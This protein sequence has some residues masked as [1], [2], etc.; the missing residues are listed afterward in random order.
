MNMQ[1]R[2]SARLLASAAALLLA[3]TLTSCGFDYATDRVYTPGAGTNERDALVDVLNAVIVSGQDGSGTFV[4]SF[5]NN[6]RREEASVESLEGSGEFSSLEVEDFEPVDL[7]PGQLVNLAT[8]GGIVVR[9]EFSPGDFVTVDISFGDGDSVEM[10]VPTV[11]NCGVYEGLDI[12]QSDSS[13][14]TSSESDQ[15]AE[16]GAPEEE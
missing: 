10:D 12:S 3:T 7:A 16:T 1:L 5:A 2:Q 11:T 6:D 15:C 13:A 8:E 9:G 4:A 14:S